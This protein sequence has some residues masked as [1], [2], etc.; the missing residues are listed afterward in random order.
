MKNVPVLNHISLAFGAHFARVLGT[1]FAT[2]SNEIVIG[3]RFAAN[4]TAFGIAVD[5]TGGL[6]CLCALT[7]RPG[8]RLFRRDR[9]IGL[10]T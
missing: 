6:R 4:K 7:D 10:Q 5:H 9:E 2:Q 1:L 3:N 8:S